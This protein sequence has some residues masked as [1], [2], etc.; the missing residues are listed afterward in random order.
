MQLYHLL[1]RALGNS[2]TNQLKVAIDDVIKVVNL[3]A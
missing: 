3:I 1:I 2:D